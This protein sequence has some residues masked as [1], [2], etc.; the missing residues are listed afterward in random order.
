MY[1]LKYLLITRFTQ[2]KKFTLET[3][4]F[5]AV[6]GRCRHHALAS[7]VY[8]KTKSCQ[9]ICASNLYVFVRIIFVLQLNFDRVTCIFIFHPQ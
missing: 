4:Q 1:S 7:G 9:A 2:R 6:D 3:I 8:L 5:E